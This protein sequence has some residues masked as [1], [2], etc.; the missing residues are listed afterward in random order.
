MSH[1]CIEIALAREATQFAFRNFSLKEL[2]IQEVRKRPRT[3]MTWPKL[4]SADTA[5]VIESLIVKAAMAVAISR[6]PRIFGER[7]KSISS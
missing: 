5:L 1:V 6:L 2:R 7:A 3:S 4:I